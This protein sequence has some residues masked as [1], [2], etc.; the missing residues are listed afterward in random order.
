VIAF[1]HGWGATDP[2]PYQLWIEHLVKRG[3]IVIYP[4]YQ[5]NLR[6]QP[7]KMTPNTISALQSAFSK[8][9]KRAD[10][11]RV[12]IVGHSLG[13]LMAFNVAAESAAAGLP[14]PKALLSVEPGDTTSTRFGA[15]RGVKSIMEEDRYGQIPR[16]TLVIIVVGD[17]DQIVGDT[18][19]KRLFSDIRFIPCENKNFV[20][21]HSD[22]HG[23]PPLIANHFAPLAPSPDSK[24]SSA[25]LPRGPIRRRIAKRVRERMR[26]RMGDEARGTVNALDYYA[27]W[28]LSDAL[29]DFAFFGR[30]RDYALGG[31]PMQTSMGKWSDGQPVTPLEASNDPG[32]RKR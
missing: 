9:G 2:N 16:N 1:L 5:E 32:C 8:L 3:N 20:V 24:P 25:G 10:R 28:K 14:A 27:Y 31:G 19:A 23:E 18:T 7:A 12:A 13:A 4:R 17:E 21:V 6:E 30:D 15:E 11:S 26:E 29:T 22:R